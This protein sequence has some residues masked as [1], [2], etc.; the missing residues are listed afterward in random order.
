MNK[1]ANGV[2]KLAADSLMAR[3]A[4]PQTVATPSLSVSAFEQERIRNRVQEKAKISK[5][6]IRGQS[7]SNKDFSFKDELNMYKELSGDTNFEN[8][9]TI[10]WSGEQEN[11]L[12]ATKPMPIRMKNSKLGKQST[13]PFDDC[14]F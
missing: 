6:P 3:F 5:V 13:D 11:F 2:K 4:L 9:Q 10:S 1:I 7:G 14:P 12:I 8:P